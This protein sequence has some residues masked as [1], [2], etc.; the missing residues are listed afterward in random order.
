MDPRL[1]P[2]SRVAILVSMQYKAHCNDPCFAAQIGDN[3]YEKVVRVSS[4]RNRATD[5]F[6]VVVFNQKIL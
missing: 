2:G 1:K 3:F 4:K 5:L 6:S